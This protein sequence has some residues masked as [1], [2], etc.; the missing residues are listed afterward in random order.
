MEQNTLKIWDGTENSR[1][2]RKKVGGWDGFHVLYTERTQFLIVWE[3]AWKKWCKICSTPDA[4]DALMHLE[5][6]I[7]DVRDDRMADIASALSELFF[8]L[9]SI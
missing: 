7:S 2:E 6:L 4:P 3:C 5:N 9:L 1:E 8:S